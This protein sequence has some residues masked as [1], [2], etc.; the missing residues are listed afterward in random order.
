M[1]GGGGQVIMIRGGGGIETPMGGFSGGAEDKRWRMELY[2]AATNIFNHT[3]LLGYSG[4]M[5]SPFFGQATSAGP[6]RKL[7][8]GVR[9]GF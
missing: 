9:F 4:V 7:E 2:A 5:T 8:L 1:P 3:N 6:S